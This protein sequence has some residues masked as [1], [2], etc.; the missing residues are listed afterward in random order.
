MATKL[1][2]AAVLLTAARAL[3]ASAAPPAEP[4]HPSLLFSDKD[5]PALKEKVQ[6][7]WCKDALAVLKSHADEYMSVGTNPYA[8]SSKVHSNQWA[9]RVLNQ[10]VSTLTMVGL[11]TDEKKYID[12]AVEIAV[13]A[14]AQ[15]T[16]K[17]FATYNDHL[18]VGD[19]GHAFAMAYDWL[20]AY[21]TDEQRVLLRSKV[22]EFGAWL[23]DFSLPQ[24][25][26]RDPMNPTD[27]SCNHNPV[28]NG[29][30]GLCGLVLGDK[31]EWVE[32]ATKYVRGYYKY[33]RDDTGYNYEGLG[34]YCYG[35]WGAD[36]Y[37]WALKR[38]GG[39]DLLAE[40]PKNKLV[41]RYFLYQ[42]APWGG[43]CVTMND[44]NQPDG[45]GAMMYTIADNKDG[46]GLW[47]WLRLWGPEGTKTYSDGPGIASLAYAL[48]FA[49]PALKPVHPAEAK[50]PLNFVFSGGR[51]SFRSSWTD[52]LAGMATFTCGFDQHRGHNHKDE[53][54]FTFFA[55]GETFVIDPGY[56][57]YDTHSHNTV[58]VDGQLQHRT[59][60]QYD[61]NGRMIGSKDFG[62]AW[63]ISGDA[64]DAF[65]PDVGLAKAVRHL[66]FVKA[67]SPYLV[68]ADDYQKKDAAEG[69]YTWL[70]H[71]DPR[72]SFKI[73]S[74]P[75]EA[76]IVGSRRKAICRVQFLHPA[77]GLT[78]SESDLTMRSIQRSFATGKIVTSRPAQ[79]CAKF[80]KE[81]QAVARAA[82]PHFVAVLTA[83]DSEADL[84]VVSSQGEP[85]KMTITVKQKTGRTDTIR[86]TAD[87]LEFVR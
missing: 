6:Q 22:E 76:T 70:L 80:F 82:N 48:I 18:S 12:K 32:L 8:F 28:V 3:G 11:L 41:P 14:A 49:D 63:S 71:T 55:R 74:K 38:S 21:L 62:E 15:A 33:S 58:L 35:A 44:S 51:G 34:Y 5:V 66:L 54:S 53:N 47:T 84:P 69:Q 43:E 64:K 31:P 65:A 26:R 36:I 83:A 19:G 9:G 77:E 25:A 85:E 50:M 2:L 67:D 45:A 17:E 61:V 13:A 60:S 59:G 78:I 16:A 46:V 79:S 42:I 57:P 23:Y 30:L 24:K 27:L 87:G 81:L 10:H 52:D 86:L 37:S 73:G 20:Y 75:G 39:G 72:N 1:F 40:D 56:Q 29:A 4:V 68:I 7:G